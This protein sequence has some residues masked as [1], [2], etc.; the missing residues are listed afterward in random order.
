MK[1]VPTSPLPEVPLPPVEQ[2]GRLQYKT[3]EQTYAHI[4][5]DTEYLRIPNMKH[6]MRISETTCKQYNVP[7]YARDYCVH[8]Y[9][10]LTSCRF[11]TFYMPWRCQELFKAYQRCQQNELNKSYFSLSYKHLNPIFTFFTL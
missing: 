4:D 1:S 6:R 3:I 10:P 2:R 9:I 5:L 11:K 8:L 7:N